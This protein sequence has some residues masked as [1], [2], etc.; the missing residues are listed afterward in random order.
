MKRLLTILSLIMVIGIVSSCDL[1]KQSVST[2]SELFVGEI[3]DQPVK[4]VDKAGYINHMIDMQIPGFWA[5]YVKGVTFVPIK[6]FDFEMNAPTTLSDADKYKESAD[7][8]KLV[9]VPLF[10]DSGQLLIKPYTREL[11]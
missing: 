4:F 8:K 9:W 5:E 7:G 11:H 6:D 10:G 1:L 2:T 3:N